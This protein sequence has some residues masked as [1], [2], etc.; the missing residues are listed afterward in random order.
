[1]DTLIRVLR[2]RLNC[3]DGEV[4]LLGFHQVRCVLWAHKEPRI[5][6]YKNSDLIGTGLWHFLTCWL[7]FIVLVTF[8]RYWVGQLMKYQPLAISSTSDSTGAE[9]TDVGLQ[10]LRLTVGLH[11]ESVNLEAF[12]QPW[13][14]RDLIRRS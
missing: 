1:M 9:H 12:V 8:T 3:S 6:W 5:L 2:H 14:R 10:F 13:K 11:S 7:G 4:C